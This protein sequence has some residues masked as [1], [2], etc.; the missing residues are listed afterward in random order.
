MPS[1]HWSIKGKTLKV[2][3]SHLY[4]DALQGSTMTA[5][6]SGTYGHQPIFTTGAIRQLFS[7]L[8]ASRP[9]TKPATIA[10]KATQLASTFRVRVR[11]ANDVRELA[12]SVELH[13]PGFA[14]DLYAAAS[15]HEGYDD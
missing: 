9:A 15:R 13:S 8:F 10:A 6:T 2:A 5:I 1:I 4:R 7:G 14:A 12:R 11:E 3:S